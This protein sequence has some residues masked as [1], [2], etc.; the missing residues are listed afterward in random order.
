VDATRRRRSQSSAWCAA[1]MHDPVT[2]TWLTLLGRPI[3]GRQAVIA[4]VVS[5]QHCGMC[6]T[7]LEQEDPD[8]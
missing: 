2:R 8:A 6:G 3:P 1:G 5:W 7:K 4:M